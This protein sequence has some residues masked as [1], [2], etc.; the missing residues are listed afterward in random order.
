M[1]RNVAAL[2]AFALPFCLLA[3]DADPVRDKLVAARSAFAAEQKA[4][5]KQADTWFDT[6]E[7][8]ARKAG[9]KK[10]L[11]QIKAERT[12]FDDH[13]ELPKNAPAALKSQQDKALKALEAAYTQALKDYTAAKKAE[14]AAAV[15]AELKNITARLGAPAGAGAVAPAGAVDLLALIDTKAHSVLGEWRRD[16]KSVVGVNPRFPGVL[17]LPYE[18]GEEYDL[19]VTARR[20]SGKEYFAL[21][22]VAGGKRLAVAIDT[23]PTKG[24]MSGFGDLNGK[25]LLDNGTAV[26]GQYIKN[27][28]D[29]TLL[30]AVRSD[31]IDV[32]FD[33]K[34]ILTYKGEFDG[35]SV[36]SDFRV[37]NQKALAIQIGYTSP[38]KIDRLVVTPVKGK[39]AVTK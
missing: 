29:F 31:K 39:G 20:L 12:A 5:R 35:F 6:R 17:Q 1:I 36:H 19:E 27:D 2:F 9:A 22:L 21:Q 16:V 28:T 30:C 33:G 26:K 34:V 8:A 32:S 23:W 4:I 38:Y 10:L 18:P 13:E 7:D 37:P 24:Y 3:Q 11:E 15:G 14:E 25:S